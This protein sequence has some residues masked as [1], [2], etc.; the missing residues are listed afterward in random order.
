M[1]R[2]PSNNYVNRTLK[3]AYEGHNTEIGFK[4][5]Q[6]NRPSNIYGERI[7]KS[8]GN[9]IAVLGYYETDPSQLKLQDLGWSKETVN[10][11]VRIP[12]VLLSEVGLLNSD[13]TLKFSNSDRLVVPLLAK[14]YQINTIQMREP[15]REG[16]PTFVWIGG[17]NFV[18]GN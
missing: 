10:I 5:F 1:T 4:L 17:R 2:L 6:N 14:E 3:N 18:N 8:F 11:I 15:F 12:Y 7:G 9:P 13:G 16:K